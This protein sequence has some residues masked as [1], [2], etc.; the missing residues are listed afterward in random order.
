MDCRK[1]AFGVLQ[2][3][4]SLKYMLSSCKDFDEE[5]SLLQ[6]MGR[7]LEVLVDCTPK[8]HCEL[9]GEGIEYAWGCCKN[10]YCPLPLKE[11]KIKA[12][13]RKCL[14]RDV[15]TQT[16]IRLFSWWALQYI[17]AYNAIQQASDVANSMMIADT[18]AL[19]QK[20]TQVKIEQL[21]KQFKPHHCAMDF[22]SPFIKSVMVKM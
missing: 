16:C 1:D 12:S 2:P 11:K 8:C 4:T 21:V 22:D 5:E 19:Q 9:A 18:T 14:S 15:L 13:V 20:I 6:S 3:T 7:K 17:L 10:Y